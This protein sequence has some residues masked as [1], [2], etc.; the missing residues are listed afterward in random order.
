MLKNDVREKKDR[1]GNKLFISNHAFAHGKSI[2]K[3]IKCLL[4]TCWYYH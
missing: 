3:Y 2:I 1:I 4:I